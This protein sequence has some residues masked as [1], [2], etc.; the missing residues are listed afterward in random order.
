MSASHLWTR[1]VLPILLLHSLHRLSA[2]QSLLSLISSIPRFLNIFVPGAY[3]EWMLAW[4]AVDR[5]HQ[6][7][8]QCSAEYED[9][10]LSAC[11]MRGSW[12]SCKKS[13]FDEE[14]EP[15]LVLDLGSRLALLLIRRVR[16][17]GGK[18]S[19]HTRNNE[20]GR[21]MSFYSLMIALNERLIARKTSLKIINIGFEHR[22]TS[23]TDC[24]ASKASSI[25]CNNLPQEECGLPKKFIFD[26]L[27]KRLLRRREV[28][29]QSTRQLKFRAC[30]W[31]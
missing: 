10:G 6:M 22:F 9:K 20:A 8:L 7:L 28:L 15:L 16:L 26:V 4:F 17:M 31:E 29:L 14:L 27:Y 3:Y 21:I 13:T 24:E 30:L 12:L 25:I 19:Y 23:L 11:I 18:P 1:L 5:P 2:F